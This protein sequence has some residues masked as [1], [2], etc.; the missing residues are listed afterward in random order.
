MYIKLVRSI[1][2]LSTWTALGIVAFSPGSSARALGD[3]AGTADRPAAVDTATGAVTAET[4]GEPAYPLSPERYEKLVSY[5][6]LNQVWLFVEFLVGIATLAIILVSGLSARFRDW[7]SRLR[8]RFFVIWAFLA[9]VLV[10]DYL[11][12]FPVHVYRS[13]FVESGYGFMNQTF[14]QWLTDDLLQLLV[15]IV[16]AAVPVW[17]FY[18]LVQK[19]RMWWLVFTIGA[20]PILVFVIVIAPLVIDPLFNEFTPLKDTVLESEIMTLA[21]RGGVEGSNIFEVNASRQSSKVSAYMTGLF[22]SRRIVLYDNLLKNL[23]HDE[24]QFVVG[25]EM[26]HYV[27]DHLWQGIG[28]LILFLLF[29][30]WLVSRTIHR[31]IARFSSRFRFDRLSDIASLPLVLI[32]LLVISFVA[33]PVTNGFGRYVESQADKYAMDITG[34]SGETAAVAFDKLAVYNLSDPDPPS[35]IEFWFYNHPSLKKRMEFVRNYRP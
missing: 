3:S 24:I 20:T 4:P 22:G 26:G 30:S 27:M 15:L 5:S 17:F 7:A 18:W 32:F 6:R 2:L 1:I 13:F 19:T 12:G 31:V 16:V 11:L 9:L 29:T 35:F 25:H 34:V 28:L 33:Q 14:L 8:L 21:E 10:A 23:S